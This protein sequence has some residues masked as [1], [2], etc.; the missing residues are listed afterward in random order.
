MRDHQV[1]RPLSIPAGTA[2]EFRYVLT[3]PSALQTAAFDRLTQTG[4]LLELPTD[5]RRRLFELYDAIDR[6]N[7]LHRH[8]ETLHYNHLGHVHV[9]VDTTALD[10]APGETATEADLPAAVHEQLAD[11]RRLRQATN[12]ISRQML[13]LAA[14]ICPPDDV[15]EPGHG[16][17][18]ASDA[19]ATA[20]NGAGGPPHLDVP[21]IRTII[22]ELDALEQASFWARYV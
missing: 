14:A 7:R 18:P 6:L 22:R 4:Q 1:D 8:R 11:L 16:A 9:L 13:R 15:D 2:M 21:A 19:T 5:L 12:G 3:L 17:A 10:L 20:T